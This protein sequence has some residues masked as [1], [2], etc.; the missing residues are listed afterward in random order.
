[1]STTTAMNG[2]TVHNNTTRKIKMFVRTFPPD[3]LLRRKWVEYMNPTHSVAIENAK[4]RSI[5]HT[6]LFAIS[7][8]DIETICG[9]I[10]PTIAV[11]IIAGIDFFNILHSFHMRYKYFNT[12]K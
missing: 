4:L 2:A 8:F 10:C 11:I 7:M 9:T 1:M 3:V 6:N 5:F 12:V